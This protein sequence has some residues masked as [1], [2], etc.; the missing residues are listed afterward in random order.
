[1]ASTLSVNLKTTG[2]ALN[3]GKTK[4]TDEGSSM[5]QVNLDIK[6]SKNNTHRR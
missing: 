1:M 3:V 6:S 2:E 4:E 5:E